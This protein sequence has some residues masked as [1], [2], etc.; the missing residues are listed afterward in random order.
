MTEAWLTCIAPPPMWMMRSHMKWEYQLQ[1]TLSIGKFPSPPAICSNISLPEELPMKITV[2]SWKDHENRELRRGSSNS[3]NIQTGKWISKI[4]IM[5]RVFLFHS[6]KRRIKF[7]NG[8]KK[9]LILLVS[10]SRIQMWKNVVFLAPMVFSSER[11]NPQGA[12]WLNGFQLWKGRF[13]GPHRIGTNHNP[14]NQLHINW[15]SLPSLE[16]WYSV[17]PPCVFWKA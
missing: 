16:S 5:P 10:V 3:E 9:R 13:F 8:W 6:E 12:E 4:V 15:I 17:F 1:Q 14:A 7:E 2:F 11:K